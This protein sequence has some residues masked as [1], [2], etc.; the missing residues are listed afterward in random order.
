MRKGLLIF[1]G[2]TGLS[3]G[4]SAAIGENKLTRFYTE[5]N[6]TDFLNQETK[7]LEYEEFQHEYSDLMK[8]SKLHVD[9]KN[10]SLKYI[11]QPVVESQ[12]YP[13]VCHG[14]FSYSVC[15]TIAEEHARRFG[16]KFPIKKTFMRY[17]APIRV[18]GMYIIEAVEDSNGLVI[19]V[20]DKNNVKYSNMVTT[21]AV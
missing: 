9:E 16:T 13:G 6:F 14:G 11:Y 12:G 8:V 15:L 7:G 5:H 1:L 20:K 4:A 19:E 18:G 17:T 3:Y 21:Y 2:A 10:R